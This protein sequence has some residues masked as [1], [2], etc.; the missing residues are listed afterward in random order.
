MGDIN[1]GRRHIAVNF[2]RHFPDKATVV[3]SWSQ[4][5]KFCVEDKM[6]YAFL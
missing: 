6:H 5:K 2:G 4:Q 3:C 1:A